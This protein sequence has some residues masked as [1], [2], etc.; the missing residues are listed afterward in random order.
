MPILIVTTREGET[1]NLDARSGISIMENI[2]E[3][4]IDELTAI[5]GGCLSCAT[6]HVTLEPADY[7]RLPKMDEVENDLLDSSD[8]RTPLS[9]LSC[10]VTMTDALDGVHVTIAVE[11]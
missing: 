7:A 4:G 5:C 6:C 1:R 10:Q 11:D 8:N 9:R 2:R 3:A